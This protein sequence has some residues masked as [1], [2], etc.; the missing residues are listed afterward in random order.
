VTTC[1][2]LTRGQFRDGTWRGPSASVDAHATDEPSH[3][4]V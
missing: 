3:L 4:T 2:G 1:D